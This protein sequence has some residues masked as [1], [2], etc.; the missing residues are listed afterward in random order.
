LHHRRHPRLI[1][2]ASR[3]A[4]TTHAPVS[5]DPNEI[6]EK[7]E[8]QPA[9]E[10]PPKRGWERNLP[11]RSANDQQEIV[12]KTISDIT[13]ANFLVD[14]NVRGTVTL[15]SPTKI[16]LGE[17]FN[18]LES[19]LEVRGYAA[20]ASDKIIKIVPRSEAARRNVH[21][22]V[23]C[24]PDAIPQTDTVVTQIM[25]L[26]YAGVDEVSML[27]SPRVSSGG[28]FTAHS[29]TNTLFI[30]DTS[31]N[32][33]QIARIIREVDVPRSQ[34]EPA[35]LA[36]Q[37]AS[38]QILSQ[39]ISQ[40]LDARKQE[41]SRTIASAKIIPDQRTNS[42]IVFASGR[43]IDVV[44][45]L[46]DELDVPRAIETGSIHVV[47]LK[48]ASAQD[49]VA[50]L[51][52]ALESISRQDDAQQIRITADEGTNS[53]VIAASPQDYLVIQDIIAKLDTVRE[54][55]LVE[56]RIIEAS[57]ETLREIGIDWAT[58]DEAVA[59][60]IRGFGFTNFGL[61]HQAYAGEL[62]GLGAGIHKE[63]GGEVTIGAILKALESAS[64]VNVLSTPHILT[65]NN[66]EATILVGENVP[67][68]KE[69]RVTETDPT[70]PTVIK[71][72]DYKDVGI[73]LQITPHISQ[74]GLVR[75]AI[76]SE[77]SKLIEDTART[78][79]DTPVT[80]MRQASTTISVMSGST[81]VIGGLMRD[82]TVRA[83]R[84][85]PLLADIPL[86]GNLFKW[87]KNHVQKTNLLLF[88]TPHVLTDDT[89]LQQI[90]EQKETEMMQRMR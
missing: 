64:N 85:V 69:S 40:I 63:I 49:M 18:V 9:E 20:V 66:Q 26:Q 7:P 76:E 75:L 8:N 24:N 86:L 43:T 14:D 16:R 56:L 73:S 87:H 55:V 52:A 83:E 82:D 19:I 3:A 42:L 28:T 10:P 33:H 44:K 51:S 77:F 45:S 47:H 41:G 68:V 54:Q 37:H 53:L 61:R 88:I 23:G 72:Y 39:Q 60:G 2:P 30:T 36:L 13:G 70:S 46:V 59:D 22:R 71:T 11:A 84:R 5:T 90:S 15:M 12:L 32:I 29:A 25:P 81:V 50:S 57:E 80:S 1:K 67:Y 31:A 38:A 35:I 62:Q 65:S 89:D 4:E 27:V 79:A 48:N 34:D 74:G 21:T 78:T 6:A 17:V 58:L